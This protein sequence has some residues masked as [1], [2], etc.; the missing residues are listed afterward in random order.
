MYWCSSRDDFWF[1]LVF[2]YEQSGGVVREERLHRGKGALAC[3][4]DKPWVKFIMEMGKIQK[5]TRAAI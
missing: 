2:F 4:F 1:G 3:V 5:Y